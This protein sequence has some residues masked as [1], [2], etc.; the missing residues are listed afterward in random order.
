MSYRV[1]LLA[2]FLDKKMQEG[3]NADKFI[4]LL[5]AER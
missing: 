3:E 1:A 4:N 5:R 2:P